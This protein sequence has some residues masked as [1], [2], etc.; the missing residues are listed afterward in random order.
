MKNFRILLNHCLIL[1]A[2]LAF[3][4]GSANNTQIDPTHLAKKDAIDESYQAHLEEV[5]NR[6]QAQIEELT[7][8]T[9]VLSEKQSS[10]WRDQATWY[11][12][13]IAGILGLLSI[14]FIITELVRKRTIESI[15]NLKSEVEQARLLAGS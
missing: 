6:Y 5:E 9:L 8:L 15:K 12:A 14:I 1:M 4:S 3:I 7:E 13:I 10:F 11:T 2:C